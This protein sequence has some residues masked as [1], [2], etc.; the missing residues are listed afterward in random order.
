MRQGDPVTSDLPILIVNAGIDPGCPPELA[1]AA[2]RH[3]SHGQF[4]LVPNVTHG[5]T[6]N[7]PCGASIARAFLRDPTKA[8]D[9]TCLRTQPD[10]FTFPAA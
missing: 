9:T 2:L 5:A 4:V 3:L 7:S 8:V 6:R 10:S 1:R